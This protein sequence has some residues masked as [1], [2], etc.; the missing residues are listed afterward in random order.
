[1]AAWLAVSMKSCCDGMICES[2]SPV[3]SKAFQGEGS[4]VVTCV[5]PAVTATTR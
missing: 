1:M 3:R 2:P 4:V 5:V